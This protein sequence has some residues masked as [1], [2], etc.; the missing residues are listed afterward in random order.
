[1]GK[2]SILTASDLQKRLLLWFFIFLT[3]FFVFNL[4]PYDDQR[5]FQILWHHWSA[6][7]GPA[8]LASEGALIFMD[9]PVQ[10]GA[11]PTLILEAAC[12]LDCWSYAYLVFAFASFL[13]STVICLIGFS[14]SRDQGIP[15]IICILAMCVLSSVV[16]VSSPSQVANPLMTPSTSGMRFLPVLVLTL[17]VIKMTKRP[18]HGAGI[19]SLIWLIGCAWSI[20]SAFYCSIVWLP[21]FFWTYKFENRGQFIL[22]YIF[23][24]LLSFIFI[25]VI[26]WSVS[27]YA[28]NINYF[29]LYAKNP[30]GV[31]PINIFGPIWFFI[32]IV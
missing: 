30:P 17:S 27:D 9:M 13:F 14:F 3:P 16:W 20:E 32:I 6:Y 29:T 10:Y 26:A 23:F 11:L 8:E 2:Q 22:K 28:F 12:K 7:I 31:L 25:L 24:T 5:L 1:L 15:Y 18:K 21:L 4:T 19:S